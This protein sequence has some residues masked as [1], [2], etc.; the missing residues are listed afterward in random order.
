MTMS[1]KAAGIVWCTLGGSRLISPW[2][3]WRCPVQAESRSHP[4]W[5]GN[6][7]IE[8]VFHLPAGSR[9]PWGKGLCPSCLLTWRRVRLML[10]TSGALK[11]MG[12]GCDGVCGKVGGLQ[13]AEFGV[14]V[15][16]G[17]AITARD[18]DTGGRCHLVCLMLAVPHGTRVAGWPCLKRERSRNC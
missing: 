14:S 2:P 16:P 9:W 12:K 18:G 6:S 3:L 17:A 4:W 1:G 15:W 10:A 11:T 13:G 7:W 5:Q 8:S